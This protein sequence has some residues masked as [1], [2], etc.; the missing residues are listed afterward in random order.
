ME[1]KKCTVAGA[2]ILFATLTMPVYL[3][4]QQNLEPNK[5]HARYK[6]IDLGTFGGPASYITNG[7]DGILNNR[8]TAAGWAD[9]S[10]P[11]PYPDFCFNPDC[12]ISHAFASNDGA[13]T[14]LGVLP[15]GASSSAWW[16]SSNGLILG[17]SQNG[18]I[19]PLAPGLPENRAVVW[20]NGR[21]IDLGT[22]EGGHESFG[23]SVNSHGQAVGLAF[24]TVPD[25]FSFFGSFYPYQG[26][27]FLWQNGAMWD[28]GTLGRSR[29]P[30]VF[31]ERARPSYRPVLH[32]LDAQSYYRD[33]HHRSV[34]L[35]EWQNA[36]HR[37]PWGHL[38]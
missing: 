36:G 2:T 11:D 22:L 1:M 5:G 34:L 17:N 13:L 8:G 6:F 37:Y 18:R 12:M 30:G 29:R 21:I 25:P 15:G 28:L 19:D 33:T 38:R 23:S 9:M 10:S 31:C 24:S 26:R 7:F 14:D 27:A 35:G 32:K 16:T 4:G 3:A 20:S